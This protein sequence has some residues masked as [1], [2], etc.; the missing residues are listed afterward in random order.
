MF[1]GRRNG[2][3]KVMRKLTTAC[4]HGLVCAW[5]D[6]ALE[7][8]SAELRFETTS[9]GRDM[10]V[11]VVIDLMAQHMRCCC[12]VLVSHLSQ[13]TTSAHSRCSA[14]WSCP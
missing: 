8:E 9:D 7:L 5:Q 1:I 2:A 4:D 10:Q 13:D 12:F 11:L 3:D 14:R 6:G